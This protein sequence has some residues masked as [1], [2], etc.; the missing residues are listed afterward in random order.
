MTENENSPENLRKF[1]ESDDPAMVRMGL[2]MAKGTKISDDMLALICGLYMWHDETKVRSA[3]RTIF[4]KH[5][6]DKLKTLHKKIWQTN[7]RKIKRTSRIINIS[8]KIISD[9]KGTPLDSFDVWRYCFVNPN[10]G[11]PIEILDKVGWNAFSRRPA[12]EPL[13]KMLDKSLSEVLAEP[14]SLQPF[15]F[16]G[17]TKTICKTLNSIGGFEAIDVMFRTLED[18]SIGTLSQLIEPIFTKYSLG[19]ALE[20]KGLSSS[21]TREQ[22]FQRLLDYR[23]A[24]E[25]LE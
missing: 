16:S 10:C 9:F 21:G 17:E 4:M 18:R 24:L 20:E 5:A 15:Y 23:E 13:A 2:S 11:P 6:P 12:V 19:T 1:L 3:A 7:Y 22:L 14:V 25:K 8:E